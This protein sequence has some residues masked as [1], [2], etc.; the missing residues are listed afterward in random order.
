MVLLSLNC[1]LITESTSTSFPVKIQSEETVGVLKDEIIKKK[2]NAFE[3][4]DADLLRRWKVSISVNESKEVIDQV[5]KDLKEEHELNPGWCLQGED[6]L[7]DGASGFIHIAVKA[8]PTPEAHAASTI[9][10]KAIP[11]KGIYSEL[12]QIVEESR[13]AHVKHNI[14]PAKVVAAQKKKLG[15][16]YEKPL[17]YGETEDL[18]SPA[19]LGL[20]RNKQPMSTDNKT[21]LEIVGRDVG[22][23]TGHSV[24]AMVG[25]S[26]SGK[27]ATV[28]DLARTHFVIYCIC[29]DPRSMASPDFKDPNFVTLAQDVEQM[30]ASFPKPA[31]NALNDLVQY[32]T[33]LKRLAGE[34]VMLEFLARRLFL[35]VLF[36]IDPNLEPL[37]FFREQANGGAITIRELVKKL[38]MY[39]ADTIVDMHHQV[40]KSLAEYLTKRGLGLVVALDEA[41]VAGNR[42]LPRTFI[43]PSSIVENKI[44]DGKGRILDIHLRGFLTPLCAT[45]SHMRSTLVVLGTSM[46]LQDADD[47][48]PAVGKRTNFHRITQF[49]VFNEEDVQNVL[50]ELVDIS[51][52]TIP[53]VKRQKLTG[54]ARF[55][56]SVVTE[57]FECRHIEPH[58]SKQAKLD[59]VV[60]LAIARSKLSLQ[61]G[62][63]QLLTDDETGD[64]AHLLGRMVLAYK[65]HG[66]KTQFSISTQADFVDKA[67]CSLQLQKDGVNWLM[68]EPL[69]VEVVEEELKLLGKD[70]VFLGHLHQL[71][72]ILQNLGLKSS[73]KGN[74]LEPLVWRALQRFNNFYLVDL[75]FLK[76]IELPAWCQGLKLQ[77]NEINTAQGYGY[78]LRDDTR[79]DLQLLLE[80]PSN[81]LLAEKSGTRQDGAWFFSNPQYAGSLGIKFYSNTIPQSHH[82]ENE[83]STDIRCRFMKADGEKMYKSLSRIREDFVKSGGHKITGILR[84]HIELPCVKGEQHVTHIK[85]DP[86]TGTED[87]MVYINMSNMDDFFFDGIEEKKTEIIRLRDLIRYV[88]K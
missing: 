59:K 35:Q 42:I 72:E 27:T 17:P 10:K 49:P 20:L 55:S 82:E 4:I 21:L 67:V 12:A 81:K 53:R 24:V 6:L 13:Q 47:V 38:R 18:M 40:E 75:P 43:A 83:T 85:K 1:I 45:L 50:S 57:M 60:D 16:F 30:Y 39:D 11:S 51:D 19:M 66:G 62:V 74:C 86:A 78:G 63:R 64:V 76:G 84:I 56:A 58:S 70:L 44:L 54:R 25:R 15:P 71:Y 29:C 65:L 32:D 14:D 73:A 33:R 69:V 2:P 31:L 9:R 37:Q 7:L 34:R 52:C 61:A 22:R 36:S 80:R 5:L 23:T 87:V 77:I 8:P 68:E 46:S 48:Y 41:Q 28:I 79:G 88:I 3:K 26:G